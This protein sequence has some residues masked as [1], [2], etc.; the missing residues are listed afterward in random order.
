MANGERPKRS[1]WLVWFW[2]LP[3]LKQ[4]LAAIG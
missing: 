2:V 3:L 1:R 4:G